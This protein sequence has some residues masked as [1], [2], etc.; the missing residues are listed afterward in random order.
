MR[1]LRSFKVQFLLIATLGVC[2]SQLYSQHKRVELNWRATHFHLDE[3]AGYSALQGLPFDRQ[4][5][6]DASGDRIDVPTAPEEQINYNGAIWWSIDPSGQM[7]LWSDDR[8]EVFPSLVKG[9]DSAPA[10]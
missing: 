3:K 2:T 5:F 4:Y 10:Y 7:R 1:Y 8:V 9:P 6:L